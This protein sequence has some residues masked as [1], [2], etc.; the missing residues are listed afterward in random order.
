M[1]PK[2][3]E[4]KIKHELNAK[5]ILSVNVMIVNQ[6]SQNFIMRS[7]VDLMSQK[8]LYNWYLDKENFV[9]IR[10]NNVKYYLKI[11]I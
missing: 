6:T 8:V 3:K 7:Q 4:L 5:D 1:P 10:P 9:L 2:G 11:I